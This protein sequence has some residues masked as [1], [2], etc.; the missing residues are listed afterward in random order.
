[1]MRGMG[2]QDDIP[3]DQVYSRVGSLEPPYR[4][5]IGIY[6]NYIPPHRDLRYRLAAIPHGCVC[7]AA[8]DDLELVA[9]HVPWMGAG[10]IVVNNYFN[11][12]ASV[13]I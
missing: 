7:V 11:A 8:I 13:S 9:V 10:V 1:M 5:S 6:H 4:R 12:E 2:R 3:M